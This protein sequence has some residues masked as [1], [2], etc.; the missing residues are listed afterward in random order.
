MSSRES[1]HQGAVKVFL[2]GQYNVLFV[3][4]VKFVQILDLI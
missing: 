1:F 3:S 4:K 2:K